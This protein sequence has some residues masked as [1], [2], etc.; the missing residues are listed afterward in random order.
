VNRTNR[1]ICVNAHPKI[2]QAMDFPESPEKRKRLL[3]VMQEEQ[4]LQARGRYQTDSEWNPAGK[5]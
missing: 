4:K 2:G 5:L 1:A 3:A